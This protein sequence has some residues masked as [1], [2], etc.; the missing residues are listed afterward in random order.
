MK[1]KAEQQIKR[2]PTETGMVGT[3]EQQAE[4]LAEWRALLTP[5]RRAAFLLTLPS[6]NLDELSTNKKTK[7]RGRVWGLI[8]I[9]EQP[10]S[11]RDIVTAGP[12]PGMPFL[13]D[14]CPISERDVAKFQQWLKAGSEGLLKGRHWR[15]PGGLV[16]YQISVG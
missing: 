1:N 2:R 13:P 4:W 15:F 6:V 5:E 3:S 11:R 8:R 16:D 9:F 12:F 10:P 14:N 7:V